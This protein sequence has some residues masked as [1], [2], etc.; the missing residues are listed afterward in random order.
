MFHITDNTV[1]MMAFQNFITEGGTLALFLASLIFFLVRK[2]FLARKLLKAPRRLHLSP[3]CGSS[4]SS[5]CSSRMQM[6]RM[7]CMTRHSRWTLDCC[8]RVQRDLYHVKRGLHY[9]KRDLYY[10]E[11]DYIMWKKILCE[12]RLHQVKEIV[13]SVTEITPIAQLRQQ[14]TQSKK[15]NRMQ[16]ENARSKKRILLCQDT[17]AR[18]KILFLLKDSLFAQ[19]FTTIS[20]FRFSLSFLF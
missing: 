17:I 16:K 6:G 9:V 14:N 15:R 19:R 10:V 5:S 18:E 8:V 12:K 1:P 7:V 2:L 3:S 13:E 4:C 20:L 11:R